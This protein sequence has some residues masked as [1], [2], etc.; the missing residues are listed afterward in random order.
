MNLPD[1]ILGTLR[2]LAA[3]DSITMTEAAR[4]AIMVWK[5]LD[6]AQRAGQHVLLRDP[7]T[8]ETERVVFR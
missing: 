2:E 6:D 3:R 8:K 5:L 1:E 4:R 7:R